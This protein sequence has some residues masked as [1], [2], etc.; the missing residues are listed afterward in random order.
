LGRWLRQDG[1]AEQSNR[2]TADSW[3][4][5]HILTPGWSDPLAKEDTVAT[6]NQITLA[7]ELLDDPLLLFTSR[8]TRPL[9]T[10]RIA[11]DSTVDGGVDT[12]GESPFVTIRVWDK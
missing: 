7:G 9:A 1:R 6:E 4:E 3:L 5:G 10:F 12:D 2:C 11:V 8:G